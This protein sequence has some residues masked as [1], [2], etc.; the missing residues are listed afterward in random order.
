[1][2]TSGADECENIS[3]TEVKST[4]N[5]KISGSSVNSSEGALIKRL[6]TN[7]DKDVKP[8][9]DAN[10][11]VDIEFKFYLTRIESLVRTA[12]IDDIN[13]NHHV[14]YNMF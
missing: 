4:F 10:G 13:L 5:M 8:R 11:I 14:F 2:V 9:E 3:W 12:W 6:F 1:M 7:Y